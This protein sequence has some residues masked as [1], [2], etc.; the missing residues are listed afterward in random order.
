MKTNRLLCLLLL[1]QDVELQAA[2]CFGISQNITKGENFPIAGHI[3]TYSNIVLHCH[4]HYCLCKGLI[5]I[6]YI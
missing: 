5:I 4:F 2:V 1:L 6:Q 3:C